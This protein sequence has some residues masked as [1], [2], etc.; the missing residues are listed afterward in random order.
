VPDSCDKPADVPHS[1]VPVLYHKSARKWRE[2]GFLVEQTSSV[3][4]FP[5]LPKTYATTKT[6][7]MWRSSWLGARLHEQK[8]V[9]SLTVFH[10]AARSPT[11]CEYR[12][13][14][15]RKEGTQH[16]S[17]AISTFGPWQ[18]HGSR[19]CGGT[20]HIVQWQTSNNFTGS[21]VALP[22]GWPQLVVWDTGISVGNFV[23][24]SQANI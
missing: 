10:L 7:V 3:N 12:S 21:S 17:W 24:R 22:H 4:R 2:Q 15:G 11:Y 8:E 6:V 16:A 14:Q 13:Q 5:S 1:E 20:N 18:W 23:E 9:F 19:A